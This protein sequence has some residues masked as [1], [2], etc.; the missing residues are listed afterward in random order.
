M[1]FHSDNGFDAVFGR[2]MAFQFQIPAVSTVPAQPA[3]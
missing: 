3:L 1:E 2:R